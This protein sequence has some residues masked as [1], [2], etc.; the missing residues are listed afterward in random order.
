VWSAGVELL[1]TGKVVFGLVPLMGIDEFVKG[2]GKV[3]PLGRNRAARIGVI[4]RSI[5][6]AR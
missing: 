1:G 4:A 3:R 6:M 2:Y 5:N